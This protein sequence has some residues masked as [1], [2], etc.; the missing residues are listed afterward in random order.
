MKKLLF[1][2]VLS[3][4]IIGCVPDKDKRDKRKADHSAEH[5]RNEGVD[6]AALSPN[7]NVVDTVSTKESG[8]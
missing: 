3:S 6:S 2:G 4:L 1:I 8:K 5:M 7:K